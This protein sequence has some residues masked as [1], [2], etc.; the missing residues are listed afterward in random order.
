VRELCELTAAR[1]A[2]LVRARELSRREVVEAHAARISARNGELGALADLRIEAALAEAGDADAGA[3]PTGGP[4]DG[5]P[6]SIKQNYD[7]EGMATTLGIP[8]RATLVAERDE[9]G[10]RRLREAGAIVLGKGNM[11]DVAIRWNTLSSLHGPTRNPRDP[12]LSV[13]GSTGGDAA[14]V[15]AG[16]VATGL[17]SDYGGSLRVP[18][19]WCGVLAFRPSTGLVARAPVLP[20]QDFPP[21]YDLMASSG[22]VARSAEDLELAFEVLRGSSTQDP[23]SVPV[24]PAAV[25]ARPGPVALLI[26]ET[27]AVVDEEVELAVR[28][29][30]DELRDRGYRV[31]EGVVPDLRSAP[32]LFAAIVGTELIQ[33]RLRPLKGQI[34][35]SALHHIETLY[36]QFELGPRV[37]RYLA[38]LNK[39]RALARAVAAWMEHYPLVLAPVAGMTAPPLDYDEL[40]GP[41]A[42]RALFDRMRAVLWVNLLGLPAVALG[43][44]AQIVGRRFHDRAVLR[45]AGDATSR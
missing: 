25:P 14:A 20:P 23:A 11:P 45:A 10:V 32:E 40:I 30:A 2:A 3:R 12:S 42:T 44:G 43:N 24:E 31:D 9:E 36:G 26:G 18:A 38:A 35:A 21:S 16:M 8:S 17:G 39:R 37:E 41:E 7:V 33:H 4:L 27:G 1:I 5:V 13:G 34:S 22:T 28:A 6:L 19:T 15:A 29:T